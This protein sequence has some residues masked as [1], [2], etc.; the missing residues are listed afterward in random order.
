MSEPLNNAVFSLAA[1]GSLLS[2]AAGFFLFRRHI[3]GH[4][5]LA[6]QPRRRVPWGP[7]VLVIPLL[8]VLS[9]LTPLVFPSEAN[10][11]PSDPDKYVLGGL[12]FSAF[13]LTFVALA[14]AWLVEVREADRR[15]LGLPENAAQL[16]SDVGIGFVACLASLLPIYAINLLLNS[17]FTP[18]EQHPLMEQLS[19]HRTPQMFIVAIVTALI[20]APIFEEFTFRLLL[21]GWLERCED[22][23]LGY[24]A[25]ARQPIVTETAGGEVV[26]VEP[27]R[28]RPRPSRGW[29]TSLPHGWMPILISSVL[30]GLAH[31]G[32][33]VAPVPLVLLGLV[34][35]YLYQRTH[36]IVPCIVAHMLF[37]GYSLTAL[38]LSFGE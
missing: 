6:Y 20:A 13:L 34:L 23:A 37:N 1:T 27:E 22:E 8:F 24:Q 19:E 36:R 11:E 10:Q 30:F 9:S 15:D 7:M 28:D 25:T 31:V 5:L 26:E 2:F 16:G 14:V 21:Q 4:P 32:H 33:G 3:D 12:F 18:E 38:W 35:G 29:I 17:I